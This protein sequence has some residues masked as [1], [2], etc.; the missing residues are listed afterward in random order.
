MVMMELGVMMDELYAF[1]PAKND[2]KHVIVSLGS[3]AEC[4]LTMV[5]GRYLGEILID[6]VLT[7]LGFFGA[8]GPAIFPC[9]LGAFEGVCDC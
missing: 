8:D 5:K 2:P 7:L 4:V 1:E 9:I 6:D 3:E